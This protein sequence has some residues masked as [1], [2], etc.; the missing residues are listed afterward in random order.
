MD[1][2]IVIPFDP[3]MTAIAIVNELTSKKIKCNIAID[4]IILID[5]N[6]IPNDPKGYKIELDGVYPNAKP[7]KLTVFTWNEQ[8][9]K[10]IPLIEVE[11]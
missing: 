7:K 2:Q 3:T 5:C 4:G 8:Q 11:M 6:T 10:S 9:K 1:S